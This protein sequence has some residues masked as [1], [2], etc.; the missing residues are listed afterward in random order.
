MVRLFEGNAL[1]AA[2]LR[3]LMV[4]LRASMPKGNWLSRG[5]ANGDYTSFKY[6]ANGN[7]TEMNVW[8][9]DKKTGLY[10]DTPQTFK[11]DS[12]GGALTDGD[13]K[14]KSVDVDAKTG[15]ISYVLSDGSKTT[16]HLDGRID[17]IV[18]TEPNAVKTL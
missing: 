8:Q 9:P 17:K 6:D 1:T 15:D 2:E 14:Y 12:P 4:L 11:A 3:L 18:G 5:R 16:Q 10:P 7:R 13:K